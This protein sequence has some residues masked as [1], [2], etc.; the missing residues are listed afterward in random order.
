T[1]TAMLAQRPASERP[2][3]FLRIEK[4][5]SLDDDQLG[6]GFPDL[7]DEVFGASSFM[8]E[9]LGYVPIEPDGSVSVQVPSNVAFVFSVLDGNG[10]RLFPEHRAWLQLRP[11]EIRR[12]AGCH[13]AATSNTQYLSHGRGSYTAQWVPSD[14]ISPIADPTWGAVR[15]VPF[16]DTLPQTAASADDKD[17]MAQARARTS[18]IGGSTCSQRLS[19]NVI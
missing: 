3:R 6:D 16:P 19:V 18:C 5:V 13:Q 17:T 4:A 1:S 8:R 14:N 11:G 2:A 9:I 10:R 7:P 15:G 12:C